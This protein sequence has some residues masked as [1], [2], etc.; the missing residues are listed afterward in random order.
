MIVWTGTIMAGVAGYSTR[1]AAVPAMAGKYTLKVE[2]WPSSLCAWM[3]PQP[4]VT[5]PCTE[6]RPSPVP[7]PTSFVVKNGSNNRDITCGVMPVPVSLTVMTWKVP[8]ATGGCALTS[9]ASSS[10][11]AVPIVKVPPSG[12]ASRALTARF[13]T[14]CSS[15]AQS[16]TDHRGFSD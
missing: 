1:T 4:R 9:S 8:G 10:T 14:I 13:N 12:M 5:I 6:A 2:P 11:A 3:I 16:A 15:C 7:L